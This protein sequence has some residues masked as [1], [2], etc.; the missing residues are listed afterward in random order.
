M[1]RSF[2]GYRTTAPLK[3]DELIGARS[4]AA[5]RFRGYRTTA[6]L[7]R[8]GRSSTWWNTLFCF[9]GYRTTAPLKLAQG[10]AVNPGCFAFPW[11][12]NHGS[13]EALPMRMPAL[14]FVTVSVVTE[15]RL[16]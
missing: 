7:K 10:A 5:D 11:L 2:R 14:A 6:P 3:L 9:R 4:G 13:I 8:I 16:H 12:P 1:K 15:P